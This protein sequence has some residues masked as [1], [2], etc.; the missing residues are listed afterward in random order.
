MPTRHHWRNRRNPGSVGRDGDVKART[1]GPSGVRPGRRPRAPS[2][3]RPGPAAA[4]RQG[5]THAGGSHPER[6]P[7]PAAPQPPT[8]RSTPPESSSHPRRPSQIA[9][10]FGGAGGCREPVGFAAGRN[11]VSRYSR[12]GSP[13]ATRKEASRYFKARHVDV[14]WKTR[15]APGSGVSAAGCAR[16]RRSRRCIATTTVPNRSC[17]ALTRES[18][19]RK[20]Q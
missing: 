11:R 3:S 13:P 14:G 2:R 1:S 12:S 5:G 7:A 4:R 19:V 18:A 8:R 15:R 9:P 17:T 10:D 20:Q 6:V 16:D